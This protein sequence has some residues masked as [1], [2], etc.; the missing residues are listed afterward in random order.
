[1]SS[2]HKKMHPLKQIRRFLVTT[3]VGGFAVVLPMALMVAI[4]QFL[5]DFVTRVISPMRGLI[6]FSPD[7]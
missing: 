3:V 2:E 7:V 1:M 6:K 4:V 5:F